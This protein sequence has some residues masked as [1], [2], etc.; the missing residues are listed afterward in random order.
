MN[1]Y[2]KILV[3]NTDV[4][5]KMIDGP[6]GTLKCFHGFSCLVGS[7]IE[8]GCKSGKRAENTFHVIFKA[9]VSYHSRKWSGH[10]Y[11]RHQD[12]VLKER[13]EKKKQQKNPMI[14]E[15]CR[16]QLHINYRICGSGMEYKD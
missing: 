4:H 16:Q 5:L 9:T 10:F 6:S 13:E 15:T 11:R 14:P 2:W 7:F 1:H 12:T 3:S 8:N